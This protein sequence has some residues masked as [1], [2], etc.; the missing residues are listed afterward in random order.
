MR[1]HVHELLE[2]FKRK[3]DA[4]ELG[5][6][7]RIANRMREDVDRVIVLGIGGSYLGAKALFV[8]LPFP[9]INIRSKITC[10]G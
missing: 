5:K 9:S 3:Q 10:V 1:F 4:S 2:Q 8:S 7:M 6:V